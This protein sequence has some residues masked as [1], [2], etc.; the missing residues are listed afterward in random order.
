MRSRR[1][2]P[3][4]AN[5]GT[6]DNQ[7]FL[8]SSPARALQKTPTVLKPFYVSEHQYCLRIRTEVLNQVVGVKKCVMTDAHDLVGTAFPHRRRGHELDTLV[9][10]LGEKATRTHR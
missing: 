1:L 6:Q 10:R 7:R 3:V 9:P 8:H 5:P 2:P 4:L